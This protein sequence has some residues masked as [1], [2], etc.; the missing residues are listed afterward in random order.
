M[1]ALSYYFLIG[2]VTT[3]VF[4]SRSAFDEDLYKNVLDPVECERQL[5]FLANNTLRNLC[6]FIFL[7]VIC[8]WCLTVV[9]TLAG[10]NFN[11]L[12]INTF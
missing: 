6:E 3:G 7:F 12:L 2:L 10:Y 9:W 4:G 8:L 11:N 5:L 1:G